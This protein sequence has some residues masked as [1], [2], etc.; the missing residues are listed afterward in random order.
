MK[1]EI[2]HGQRISFIRLLFDTVV[3]S[4]QIG[5][6]GF[7]FIESTP[8]LFQPTVIISV[9]SNLTIGSVILPRDVRLFGL[10]FPESSLKPSSEE[11][12]LLIFLAQWLFVI[13]SYT[14]LFSNSTFE[15]FGMNAVWFC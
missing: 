3:E 8:I 10:Y 13:L 9:L 14:F 15:S 5:E 4:H 6:T 2:Y 11:G 12:K 7:P 1:I